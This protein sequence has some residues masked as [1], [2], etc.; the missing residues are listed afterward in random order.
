MRSYSQCCT[1]STVYSNRHDKR[2]KN[3]DSLQQITLLCTHTMGLSIEIQ[4]LPSHHP[5]YLKPEC[6]TNETRRK[7]KIQ[8][9]N[10]R[11]KRVAYNQRRKTAS[12]NPCR[13]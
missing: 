1:E 4:P 2:H 6:S 8:N 12:A 3:P 13:V 10:T 5:Q 11:T 7:K 9:I